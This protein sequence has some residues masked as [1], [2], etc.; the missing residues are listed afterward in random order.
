MLIEEVRNKVAASTYR[1]SVHSLKELYRELSVDQIDHK[2]PNFI[3]RKS[4]NA[5]SDGDD[6]SKTYLHTHYVSKWLKS[7]AKSVEKHINI[8]DQYIKTE[9]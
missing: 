4:S 6:Q 2:I 3:G 1:N 8:K 9:S 7:K 5:T